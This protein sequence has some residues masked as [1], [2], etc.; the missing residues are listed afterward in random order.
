MTGVSAPPEIYNGLILFFQPFVLI[1]FCFGCIGDGKGRKIVTPV[2]SYGQSIL[3]F[4]L[5]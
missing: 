4:A 1:A 2:E 3:E 5:C